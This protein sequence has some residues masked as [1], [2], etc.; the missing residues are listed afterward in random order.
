MHGKYAAR[1]QHIQFFIIGDSQIC[2]FF[3]LLINYDIMNYYSFL[4]QKIAKSFRRKSLSSFLSD[5]AV[6]YSICI[7]LFG[8]KVI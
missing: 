7:Q 8:F 6:C 3:K 1:G 5:Y 4:L 2:L